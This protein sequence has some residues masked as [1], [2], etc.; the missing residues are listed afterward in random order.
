M[1][2][3]NSKTCEEKLKDLRLLLITSFKKAV[4]LL[5]NVEEQAK[6]NII[7]STQAINEL[8]QKH[9]KLKNVDEIDRLDAETLKTNTE[10]SKLTQQIAHELQKKYMNKAQCFLASQKAFR[11]DIDRY[12]ASQLNVGHL[13]FITD[14]DMGADAHQRLDNLSNDIRLLL[15]ELKT[16]EIS[17]PGYTQNEVDRLQTKISAAADLLAP[18]N[19]IIPDQNIGL[20][21]LKI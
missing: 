2:Y 6:K 9:K 10:I 21:N 20:F 11:S 13:D 5:H 8:E 1:S 16:G 14:P 17:L 19:D 18:L 7:K 15:T 4:D 12:L 3:N